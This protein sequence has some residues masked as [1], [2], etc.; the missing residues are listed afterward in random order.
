MFV[1]ATIS[2]SR[3]V[4]LDGVSFFGDLTFLVR[5]LAI[6]VIRAGKGGNLVVGLL[7]SGVP[8]ELADAALDRDRRLTS[9]GPPAARFCDRGKHDDEGGM[10]H[11]YRT[12]RV[13]HGSAS[14][15]C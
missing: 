2:V 11:V 14:Q 10:E 4:L 9:G 3:L 12:K 1:G 15:W 8:F 5:A 13:D 7:G 6:A